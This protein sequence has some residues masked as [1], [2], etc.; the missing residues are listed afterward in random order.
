MSCPTAYLVE[1]ATKSF[2]GEVDHFIAFAGNLYKLLLGI[3]H[4]V[5]GERKIWVVYIWLLIFVFP[6]HSRQQVMIRTALWNSMNI[7]MP[8]LQLQPWM[9]GKFW[10]R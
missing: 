8:L 10:V 9:V 2:I 4:H 1:E 6:I 3:K 7:G 5:A